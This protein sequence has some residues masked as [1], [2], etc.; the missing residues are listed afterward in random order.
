MSGK[1]PERRSEY[2]GGDRRDSRQSRY[3]SYKHQVSISCFR[4]RG[5]SEPQNLAV[6]RAATSHA[7]WQAEPMP[8]S[9]KKWT[10][11]KGNPAAF[12]IKCPSADPCLTAQP[13]HELVSFS[14]T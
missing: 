8:G 13:S 2:G 9:Q 1:E 5:S 6:P 4:E 12:L 7:P 11:Q 10:W 14:V 3:A